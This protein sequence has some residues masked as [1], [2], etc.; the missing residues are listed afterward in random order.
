MVIVFI[1]YI[2][3]FTEN[4]TKVVEK[5]YLL[6]T[7]DGTPTETPTEMFCRVAHALAQVEGKYGA[8]PDEIKSHK[9]S[10]FRIMEQ[11]QFTPAGRYVPIHA[12]VNLVLR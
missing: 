10:F 4:A 3:K 6:R 5:R 2:M 12:P 7:H 1:S 8:T 9:D 11:F